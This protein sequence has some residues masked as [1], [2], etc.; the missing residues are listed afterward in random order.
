[1]IPVVK[2]ASEPDKNWPPWSPWVAVFAVLLAWPFVGYG[3]IRALQ[4]SK[5]RIEDW[6]P[7]SFEETKSLYA[8]FD[9][10]GSDEFLMISWIG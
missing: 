3:A 6:L 4:S 5:N 10:F 9:R 1:M 8:F 7:A 2:N